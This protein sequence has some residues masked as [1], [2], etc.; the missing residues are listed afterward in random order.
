VP[1]ETFWEHHQR[2]SQRHQAKSKASKVE[3]FL[4]TGGSFLHLQ[5]GGKA[6]M[7][8][9]AFFWETP[10]HNPEMRVK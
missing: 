9:K 6:M 1:S 4:K 7:A 10:P 3:P 8:I 5:S 2:S